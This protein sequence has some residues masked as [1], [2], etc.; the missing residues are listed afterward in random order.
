MNGMRI[1]NLKWTETEWMSI[2]ELE[3]VSY[4][5]GMDR[6]DQHYRVGMDIRN[7]YMEWM[8]GTGIYGADIR[9]GYAEQIYGTVMWNRDIWNKYKE[10][11]YIRNGYKE[12][13]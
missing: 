6:T 5:I 12:Q 10:Q 7:K 4:G 13:I 11:R 9:N 3:W 1:A 2:T 8:Y